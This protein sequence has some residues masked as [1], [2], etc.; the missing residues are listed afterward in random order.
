MFHL[1]RG[2]KKTKQKVSPFIMMSLHIYKETEPKCRMK[3]SQRGRKHKGKCTYANTAE[4]Y[5]TGI[6]EFYY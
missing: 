5:K 1:S 3:N 2:Q 4:I 6:R